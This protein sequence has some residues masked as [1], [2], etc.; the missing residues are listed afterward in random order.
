[1]YVD[2]VAYPAHEAEHLERRRDGQQGEYV[3]LPPQ[4]RE[5]GSLAGV[6]MVYRHEKCG[7]T[8]RMAEEIIRSYLK[9]PYLYTADET[10]CGGC[11]QHVPLRQC[12][13]VETGEDLQSY[14][15]RLRA[16]TLPSK[17]GVTSSLPPPSAGADDALSLQP[18]SGGSPLQI[19]LSSEPGHQPQ[20]F[21]VTV[22]HSQSGRVFRPF[23]VQAKDEA[24]AR[25]LCRRNY[26]VIQSVALY[27]AQEGIE[28]PRTLPYGPPVSDRDFELDYGSRPADTQYPAPYLFAILGWCLCGPVGALLALLGWWTG[29]SSEGDQRGKWFRRHWVVAKRWRIWVVAADDPWR[30]AL[31]LGSE[32]G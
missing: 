6:P 5:Q 13:W 26:L 18:N 21:V 16:A 28:K 1:V 8:T 30:A 29:S 32:G 19:R 9:N 12:V 25:K 3:T 4:E 24:A 15:E 10:F 23:I 27:V 31:S 17:H 11:G 2:S 14:T 7:A 22:A 20:E